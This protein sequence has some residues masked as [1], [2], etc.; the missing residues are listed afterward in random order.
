MAPDRSQHSLRKNGQ[1][2][3]PRRAPIRTSEPTRQP[4]NLLISPPPSVGKPN[5]STE[6]STACFTTNRPGSHAGVTMDHKRC[7]ISPA[8]SLPACCRSS[9]FSLSRDAP[10]RPAA[11]AQL[12]RQ[13]PHQPLL[14]T[15]QFPSRGPTR[16]RLSLRMQAPHR[17]LPIQTPT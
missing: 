14:K 11:Q 16:A 8:L 10:R 6:G 4:L 7:H 9:A 15:R 13:C 5:P 12:H 2:R 17:P 3:T 1:P